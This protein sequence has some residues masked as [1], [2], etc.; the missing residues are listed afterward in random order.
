MNASDIFVLPSL[1]EGFPAVIPE[2]FACGKPV[3]GTRVG[4][5]PEAL[6]NQEVGLLVDPEDSVALANAISAALDR[7]WQESSIIDHA[8]I[9]SWSNLVSQILEV[10]RRLPLPRQS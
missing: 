6:T 4:G 10:Y 8:R 1:R 3:I 2:A 5:I 7:K 9:Y